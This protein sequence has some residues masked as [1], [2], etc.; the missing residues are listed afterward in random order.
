MTEIIDVNVARTAILDEIIKR[1][2]KKRI[3]YTVVANF[4]VS[5][6]PE[7]N[8]LEIRLEDSWELIMG[9]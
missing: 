9:A 6:N 1:A 2:T 8:T 4:K 3:P 5:Y 7:T